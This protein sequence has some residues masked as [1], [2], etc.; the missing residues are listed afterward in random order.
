MGHRAPLKGKHK[1]FVRWGISTFLFLNFLLP[2]AWPARVDAPI[3]L[4][5]LARTLQTPEVLAKYMQKNFYYLEDSILFNQEEYWQ[6]P[7][8]MAVRKKGDC[9]DYAIFA[10]ALL[11]RW[12]YQTFL[13]S[14][15]WNG[16][17]HTVA[18]FEKDGRWGI[19]NLDKLSYLKGSSISDLANTVHRHWDF[20]GIMRREGRIG[21]ISRKFQNQKM[22]QLNLSSLV[23]PKFGP[24]VLTPLAPQSSFS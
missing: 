19:F 17:A 2:L 5:A 9:E 14:V 24:Q 21:L 8:E 11:Q 10:Q 7:E 3:S 16:N 22:A 6:S 20:A 23:L 1:G 4:D 13:F 12:G 15:Y 18:V